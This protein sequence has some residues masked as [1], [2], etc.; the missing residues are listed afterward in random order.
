VAQNYRDTDS[1][2]KDK[3]VHINRVAKVV[4]G[5]K[6]F[7]FAALVVVGD[8]KGRV[9]IALGKA[10]EVPEAIRKA[11]E[12][13][14]RTMVK[15]ALSEGGTIP[16]EE[17]G[18]CGA[19]RVVMRPA[20][21]GTGVIAGGSVRAVVEVAGITNIL[22]KVLGSSN[23]QNVVKAAYNALERLQSRETVANRRGK[24]LVELRA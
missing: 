18:R 2:F 5:G 12:K 17:V 1:E 22:T 10:N 11:V 4:K 24:D 13:A 9:G 23:P 21:P 3:V 19:T 6:R 7:S 15:V 20:S 14:R 16:H 8:G